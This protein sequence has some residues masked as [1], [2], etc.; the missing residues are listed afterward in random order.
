MVLSPID[1]EQ[2]TF[3]VA[4]RGY[5]EEEVDQFLDEIVIA[6]RE[7]ERQL[8]DANERVAVLEEQLEANRETEERIKKTLIIAQRTADQVV[9]EAR[10]EAQQLLVEARTQASE[11]E[12]ER[13]QERESLVADLDRLRSSVGSLKDRLVALADSTLENLEPIEQDVIA[14]QPE[15]AEVE[16][17]DNDPDDV[18]DFDTEASEG[19]D[20]ESDEHPV[21]GEAGDDHREESSGQVF[22][23]STHRPW[24]R[25]ESDS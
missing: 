12:V 4:L 25:G 16:E 15:E 11:V 3:R 10:G 18:D 20:H 17:W 6:I 7:Y 21:E 23:G 14:A 2:K 22:L 5:A 1:I 8:R 24:D 19:P 9:Q 13:I